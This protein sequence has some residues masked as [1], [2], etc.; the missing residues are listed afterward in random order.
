MDKISA[1]IQA[2]L[3]SKRFPKKILKK[4]SD[5]T[6][7]EHVI[8][9]VQNSKLINE[10]IIATTD[11]KQDHAIT[12]ICKK[13]KIKFFRGS[14]NDLLDRYYY[15]AKK[16][17]C[18]IIVRITSDCPF[19]DPH[20][21]DEAIKK[22]LSNSYDYVSNNIEKINQKWQNSTCDYPQ[23]MTVE[24]SNMKTLETAWRFA[25][26]SFERE[27]VFPYVQFNQTKFNIANLRHKQKIDMIRCTI[28]REEDLKFIRELSKHLSFKNPIHISDILKVIKKYPELLKINN[29]MPYDEGYKISLKNDLKNIL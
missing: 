19:I 6:I 5:K 29:H 22:Y 28:D 24:I 27:H 17:S 4:V 3:G 15:C 10:I 21:I 13:N 7:L 18:Q 25:K 14:S 1:I 16:Y 8:D 9:Q 11:L 2:R 12:E 20:I 26:K 23:G